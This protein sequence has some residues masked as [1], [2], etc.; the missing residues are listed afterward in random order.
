[1]LEV[2]GSGLG[3]G[4]LRARARAIEGKGYCVSEESLYHD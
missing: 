2:E 1:M 3:L 4:L